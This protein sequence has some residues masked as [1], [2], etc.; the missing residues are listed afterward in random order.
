MNN[1]IAVAYMETDIIADL[2]GDSYRDRPG[3]VSVAH[4][5]NLIAARMLKK[6]IVL[7]SQSI[8]PFK[9]YSRHLSRYALN[10]ADLIYIRE[11]RTLSILSELKI[12]SKIVV[13]P[14]IAFVLASCHTEKLLEIHNKE[15]ISKENCQKKL[16]GIST[17]SLMHY[18]S[19]NKHKY[20]YMDSMVD[21]I[22]YLH[23]AYDATVVLIPHEVEHASTGLDDRFISNK[24]AEMLRYPSWLKVIRGD[25]NPSEI[26]TLIS[27]LDG[28]IAARMHA[29]I[30]GLSSN[31][32]TI[33]LSWSH[34]YIGLLE[35]IGIPECVWDGNIESIQELKKLFDRVMQDKEFIKQSLT[36]YNSFAEDSIRLQLQAVIRILKA[37]Q[38]SPRQAA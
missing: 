19:E 32:P 24:L 10:L 14:D 35:E 5:V 7:I 36:R 8:G 11:K 3:G 25:Y 2:S 18:F 6:P 33:L 34:K 21:L 13:A 9:W 17:S 30:A 22:D 4:N 1:P 26:K 29:G 38:L 12:K 28:L 31:I 23:K 37:K 27:S 20:D 16:F 15:G